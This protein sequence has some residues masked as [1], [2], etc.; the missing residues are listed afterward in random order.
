[1]ATFIAKDQQS[2]GN[3]KWLVRGLILL[4]PLFIL[5]MHPD[6][7]SFFIISTVA[8]CILF[9]FGLSW[10]WIATGGLV[11]FPLFYFLVMNVPYRRARIL[12]FM[13]PWS[14]SAHGGF[15]VIQSMLGL[16]SGGLT[17]VGLGRGQGKLFFLP[18]AHTDFTLSVL[19]EEVGFIG[20]FAV[21]LIYFYLVIRGFQIASSVKNV[22]ARVVAIGLTLAFSFQ[23]LIN[24]A[25]VTALLPTKG[26]T[27]PF[28][29]FG[30]SSLIAMGIMF[31]ILLNIQYSC[32]KQ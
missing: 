3:Y 29:S 10:Q 16:Y 9:V 11:A 26:L 24:M 7:G 6:F 25:V 18:E 14:D 15:Q 4:T 28:L 13:N 12:A 20:V 27:L 8:F 30:G 23:V 31:G 19:G 2:W 1:M 21:G 5:L 17:G 32:P 22:Y